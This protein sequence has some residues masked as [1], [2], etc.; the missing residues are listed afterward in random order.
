M[1]IQLLTM[2]MDDVHTCLHAVVVSEEYRFNSEGVLKR[3]SAHIDCV[4]VH[5]NQLRQ[6]KNGRHTL[7]H[8]E[9]REKNGCMVA[10]LL[11]NKVLVWM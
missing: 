4:R 8:W 7:C 9:Q 5:Y 2:V 11:L 1:V 6:K 10:I 3:R